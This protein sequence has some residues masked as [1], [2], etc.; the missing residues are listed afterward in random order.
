MRIS[1]TSRNGS[2]DRAEPQPTIWFAGLVEAA[3]SVLALYSMAALLINTADTHRLRS[4]AR[5]LP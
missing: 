3:A 5:H 1:A 4:S 2:F